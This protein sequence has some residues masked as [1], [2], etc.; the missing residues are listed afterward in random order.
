MSSD[1]AEMVTSVGSGAAEAVVVSAM[2]AALGTATDM[3]KAPLITAGTI[4]PLM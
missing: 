1:F 4:F 2:A 3:A